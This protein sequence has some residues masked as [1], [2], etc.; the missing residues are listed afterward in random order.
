MGLTLAHPAH[1]HVPAR[2]VRVSVHCEPLPSCSDALAA[3]GFEFAAARFEYCTVSAPS[4]PPYLRCARGTDRCM[5]PSITLLRGTC[6]LRALR[7]S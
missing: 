2:E 7:Q 3:S 4:E 5:W 1:S 6:M